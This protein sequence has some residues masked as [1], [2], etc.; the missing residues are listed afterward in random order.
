M[1]TVRAAGHPEVLAWLTSRSP[2][3]EYLRSVPPA[4]PPSQPGRVGTASALHGHPPCRPSRP[5]VGH[6]GLPWPESAWSRSVPPVSLGSW[7]GRGATARPANSSVHGAY[8][9][10][11]PAR[12]GHHGRDPAWPRSLPPLPPD[13]RSRCA[14]T[15]RECTVTVRAAGQAEV[16]A[17]PGSRRP[18]ANNRGSCHLPRHRPHQTG[19][20]GQDPAWPP[21]LPPLPPDRRSR[22][23]ATAREC[24]VTVRAAGHPEA[25][26]GPGS[27]RPAANNRG[28]CHLPR[29]RPH[30]A[31]RD[32]QDPARPP[33]LPPLPPDRR[34][35]CAAMARECMVTVRAAGHPEA[36]AGPGNHRPA[37]E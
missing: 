15:A 37:R 27:R 2:A 19:R 7:P 17:G 13:L 18:A 32:G 4:A 9:A 8:R 16:L 12:P 6:A 22:C 3:R 20:D 24:M 14:A 36:L 21:S 30:Q 33:S 23:A 34:S 28:S 29:H 26:A 10:T 5:I 11:V 1:V 35:R 25:L 31:G